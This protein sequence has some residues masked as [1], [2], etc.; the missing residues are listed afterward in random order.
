MADV[1]GTY[2]DRM[3]AAVAGMQANMKPAVIESRIAEAAINFGL[4]VAQGSESDK[5]GKLPASTAVTLGV[6]M[7]DRSVN[8]GNLNGYADGETMRVMLKG[9]IWVT[10]SVAVAPGDPVYVV[11]TTGAWAKTNASSAVLVP[12]ARWA[13]TAGIGELAILELR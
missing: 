1:Q 13:S 7:H 12:N 4:P 6:A 8:G 2:R 9:D 5:G 10:A 3:R 11:P